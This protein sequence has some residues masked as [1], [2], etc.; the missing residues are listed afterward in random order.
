MAEY[1]DLGYIEPGYYESVPDVIPPVEEG[2]YDLD[3][4]TPGAPRY[5][6]A[7]ASTHTLELAYWQP[8]SPFAPYDVQ[9]VF[10]LVTRFGRYAWSDRG[11][12]QAIED[13]CYRFDVTA[14]ELQPISFRSTPIASNILGS[15]GL[16]ERNQS[17]VAIPDPDGFWARRIHTEAIVTMPAG[18]FWLVK[19]LWTTPALVGTVGKLRY[20]QRTMEL[21]F[22]DYRRDQSSRVTVRL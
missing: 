3:V 13:L 5:R 7:F 1:I 22:G 11:V 15:V 6:T 9:P 17:R 4:G 12:P 16:I 20:A 18:L 21:S 8:G 19:G 14:I 10:S 2:E